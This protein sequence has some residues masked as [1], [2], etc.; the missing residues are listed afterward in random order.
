MLMM[1]L[2]S[3]NFRKK[4]SVLLVLPEFMLFNFMNTCSFF[5]RSHIVRY[6]ADILNIGTIRAAEWL[7]RLLMFSDF[8]SK[9]RG[10]LEK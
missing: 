8:E 5:S 3:Y 1:G 7:Y 2:S 10:F 9:M 6:Y 4:R